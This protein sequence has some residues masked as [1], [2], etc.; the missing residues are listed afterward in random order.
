MN[1]IIFISDSLKNIDVFQAT[2]TPHRSLMA[3]FSDSIR[4]LNTGMENN[5]ASISEQ[6]WHIFSSKILQLNV[7]WSWN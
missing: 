7:E 6:S 2:P 3:F 4:I 5:L 1:A